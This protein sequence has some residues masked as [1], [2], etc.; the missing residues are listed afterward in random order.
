LGLARLGVISFHH[1][2][3][4]HSI[5]NVANRQFKTKE[6]KEHF[7]SLRINLYQ[8][9]TV[10]MMEP[11]TNGEEIPPAASSSGMTVDQ[12]YAQTLQALDQLTN[13]FSF[14]K[15]LAQKA[16][17]ECGPEDVQVRSIG[18]HA[19]CFRGGACLSIYQWSVTN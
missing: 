2:H 16:I 8:Y 10:T 7:I 1:G 4:S 6:S 5:S 19:C 15:D 13:I 9:S 18:F 17:E 3:V 14:P 12:Y 11:K